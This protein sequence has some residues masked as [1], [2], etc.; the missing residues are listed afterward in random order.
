VLAAGIIAL[1]VW[2]IRWSR[3]SGARDDALDE[4]VALRGDLKELLRL[5]NGNTSVYPPVP[6]WSRT[7]N[8]TSQ[9]TQW[10]SEH[11]DLSDADRRNFQALRRV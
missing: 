6:G 1:L 4:L 9:E 8:V 11:V 5:A 7:I 3:K 10:L 2:V